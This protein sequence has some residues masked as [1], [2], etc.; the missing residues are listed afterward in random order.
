MLVKDG[1]VKRDEYMS[2]IE[3]PYSDLLASRNEFCRVAE[4]T[5]L[6]PREQLSRLQV[7]ADQLF[8][9]G[10]QGARDDETGAAEMVL[11]FFTGDTCEAPAL[12]RKRIADDPVPNLH[13]RTLYRQIDRHCTALKLSCGL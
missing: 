4:S 2:S 6:S 7:L 10:C 3:A 13:M 8:K 12:L 1:F 5:A 11:E 9:I